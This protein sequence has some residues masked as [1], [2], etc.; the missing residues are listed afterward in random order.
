MWEKSRQFNV[1]PVIINI[2]QGIQPNRYVFLITEN[3]ASTLDR[4]I[5]Y[6]LHTLGL[7]KEVVKHINAQA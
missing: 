2:I 4:H 1:I 3:A 5:N 7:G 6:M